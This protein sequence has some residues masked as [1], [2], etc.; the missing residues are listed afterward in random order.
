MPLFV[1][2][3]GAENGVL[4][5]TIRDDAKVTRNVYL[6]SSEIVFDESITA[7]E[8]RSILAMQED[9]NYLIDSLNK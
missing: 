7:E 2:T 8:Q 4:I 3:I 9:L 5:G 6:T 1:V